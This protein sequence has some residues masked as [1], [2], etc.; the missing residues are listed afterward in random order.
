MVTAPQTRLGTGPRIALAL[1]NFRPGHQDIW[2]DYRN[3]ARPPL[4]FLSGSDDHIMPPSVQRANARKYRAPGTVTEHETYPGRAHLMTA[5]DGA[6]E[7]EFT[8]DLLEWLH[9]ST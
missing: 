9:A 5:Q 4:L 7:E 6:Y 1:A 3:A 8:A 2:V